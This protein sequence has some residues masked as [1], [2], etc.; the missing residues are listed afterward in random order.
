[1]IPAKH[2]IV[3]ETVETKAASER[4]EI[5]PAE[6]KWVE[7]KVLVKEASSRMEAVAAE[8]KWVEEKILV[9]QA[10]TTWKEGRGP[11]EKVD[12]ATGEIM[13]L[14]EVPAQYETVKKKTLVKPATTRQVD[15][16]AE[17]KTVKRR[18]MTKAPTVRTIAIPAE[19]TTVKVDKQVSPP[20][21]RR[22][23]IPAEYKTVPRTEKLTDGEIAWREVLCE[24]NMTRTTVTDIQRAL[25]RAGHN[26][27][28]IDGVYGTR[29]NAAVRSFQR[30]NSIPTGGLTI[31]TIE[32]L[33]VDL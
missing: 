28:P 31:K 29:T 17:Y 24:T 19:Y 5:V 1:V 27:G 25:Q 7:E 2:Q 22:I 11:V 30:A 33:G 6:Y 10:H 23:E 9:K 3:E 32:K 12:N 4:A 21:E 13:C 15:I 16:P 18:V 26:P 14:V 20:Q 8:Y